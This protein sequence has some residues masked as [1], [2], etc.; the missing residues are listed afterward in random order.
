MTSAQL[1]IGQTVA[2]FVTTL[3]CVPFIPERTS[4]TLRWRK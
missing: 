3:T 4:P 1:S 2:M